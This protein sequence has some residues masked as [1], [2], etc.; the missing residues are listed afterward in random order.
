[1]MLLELNATTDKQ[2]HQ[3][4]QNQENQEGQINLK[5]LLENQEGQI[6][7]KELFDI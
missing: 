2:S 6:N 5:I 7:L 4:G 3:E 1:M